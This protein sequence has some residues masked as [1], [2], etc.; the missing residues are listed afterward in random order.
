VWQG[1]AIAA[2][3][4]AG[5]VAAALGRPQPSAGPGHLA[6]LLASHHAG[7][8]AADVT[9]SARA[10]LAATRLSAAWSAA[11]D[12]VGAFQRVTD[13][14][15]VTEPGGARDELEAL[16][17]ARGNGVLTAQRTSAGITGL[18]LLI[19]AV[20]DQRALAAASAYA[21]DLVSG[22]TR[23]VR[24][25]FDAQMTTALPAEVFTAET[26]AATAGLQPP[27]T[28]AGQIVVRRPGLT[29]VETYLLFRN[30]LRRI[31]TTFEPN[32]SIAGLYIRPL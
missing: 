11:I 19:G 13:H 1:A 30:G 8:V 21:Q 3:L 31:E 29:V 15:V 16:Q 32:G 25:R 24:A 7:V 12:D 10:Q 23:A 18:V 17:F 5:V 14:Y 6:E 26:A 9:P 22:Q 4:V 28:V 27:A 2:S 20:D